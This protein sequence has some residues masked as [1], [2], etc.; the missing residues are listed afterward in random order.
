[1]SSAPFT[2]FSIEQEK[3]RKIKKF[4]KIHR[5]YLNLPRRFHGEDPSRPCFWTAVF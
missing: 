3:V 5:H 4:I 2:H 1:M